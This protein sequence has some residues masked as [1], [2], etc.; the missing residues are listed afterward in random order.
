MGRWFS[1]AAPWPK[2]PAAPISADAPRTHVFLVGFPRS[3]TTLLETALSAHPDVVTLE[4][5]ECL[6]GSIQAY[7]TSDRGLE[8]L[9]A[10]DER[11]AQRRRAEYWQAVRSYGV[12]PAGRTF[13]DK[14]PLNIMHL[15]LIARLFPDARVLLAR[16]DPRD[17]VLSCFR[18]RFELNPAMYRLLTLEGAADFYDAAMALSQACLVRLPL[19]VH[20]LRHE[21]L[22]EDFEGR[23]RGVC[24]F[25][26]LE[27]TAALMDVAAAARARAID[28][29]SSAQ[30]AR[31]LNREGV[32]A[33]RRYRRQMAAVLPRLAPWAAQFG[34]PSD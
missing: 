21:D 13:V 14:L 7:L 3:G 29:P 31:G 18:R 11:E 4:E 24:A 26:G 32:G 27:W 10:L 34:Y 2:A 16:R 5:R 9:G 17:V 12:D 22:V 33:W 1:A 28:T 30:L 8:R 6:G 15:P 25:L 19:E 20:V 23:L